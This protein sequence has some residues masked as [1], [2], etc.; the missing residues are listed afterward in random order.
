[1]NDE[2]LQLLATKLGTTSEYLWGVLIKQA[3]IY[4]YLG[5]FYS[6]VLAL[7]TALL[8]YGAWFLNQKVKNEQ[9]DETT[10]VWVAVC[11][12][13][14]IFFLCLG[15]EIVGRT[16]TAALNP[17]YWALDNVLRAVKGK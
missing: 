6:I 15:G 1:M 17:E 13:A 3:G 11:I 5:S 16:I 7:L 8:C 12:V 10:Y 9:W 4:V 2:T 14:A